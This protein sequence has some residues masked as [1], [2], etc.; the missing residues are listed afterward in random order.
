M[1]FARST[2]LGGVRV[3]GNVAQNASG[4]PTGGGGGASVED[5]AHLHGFAPVFR[6]NVGHDSGAMIPAGVGGAINV[7]GNGSLVQLWDANLNNNDAVD[8]GGAIYA[9]NSSVVL[10]SGFLC[11]ITTLPKNRYCTELRQS[12]TEGSG[13]AV[14]LEGNAWYYAHRSAYILNNADTSGA[15]IH[16]GS[17]ASA[18]T[19]VARFSG[20][21]SAGG[22]SVH[23]EANGYFAAEHATFA[24]H[25]L[26][27]AYDLL[28]TG[29]FND[30]V[31]W[32]S[33]DPI[34]GGPGLVS[35]SAAIAGDC[36]VGSGVLLL[37]GVDNDP[38]DPLYVV[39][40]VRGKW[41]L[42]AASPAVDRQCAP[43]SPT[44]DLDGRP[45]P[46]GQLGDVGAF[47]RQ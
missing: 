42:G 4:S 38:S 21:S 25:G 35:P 6:L 30:N 34:L 12:H 10:L 31:I 36:N 17:G 19:S 14:R 13:G 46:V 2:A 24:D 15:A 7:I 9:E 28:S 37:S 40:P 11:D 44:T 3:A 39:D 23:V 33:F 41:H 20:Q 1:P 45:R 8:G 27:V 26:S 22:T 16:V 18:T 29:D 5:G 32:D 43:I 47:E